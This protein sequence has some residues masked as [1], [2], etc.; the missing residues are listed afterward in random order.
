MYKT[1]WNVTMSHVWVLQVKNMC[2]ERVQSLHWAFWKICGEL[3]V[4]VGSFTADVVAEE[5]EVLLSLL[6]VN[7]HSS[8]SPFT[9]RKALIS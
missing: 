4:Q 5:P 9:K 6:R 1:L 2:W 3:R 8:P 7:N